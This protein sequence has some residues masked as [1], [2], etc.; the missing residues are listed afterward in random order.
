M[1]RRPVVGIQRGR[2]T[3]LHRAMLVVGLAAT[4]PGGVE[5]QYFGQNKVQYRHMDFSVIATEHFDI[6]YYDGHRQAAIDAARMAERAYARLSHI[7]N[8]EYRQR[9]PIILYGSHTEFQQNNVTDIAEGTGGVTDPFRHRVML[10]FTGSANDFEHVLQHEIVHQFQFDV[11]ARGRIGAG[12]Q[13]LISVNPPLWLMEGMAEYL[14]LGAIDANTAM[15][16]RDAALEGR[17]PTIEQLTYD[18]RVFPYRF[19][20]GLLAHIGSRW[21]DEA[22]GEILHAVAASGVEQGLQ[23]ALGMSLEE[24]SEEWRTAV[25]RAYLPEIADRQRPREFGRPVLTRRRSSGT[26]HVSPALSPDGSEIAYFSEGKSFFVDLYVADAETGKVRRRLVKSAFSTDFESVRFLNSSGTWSR[27][28]KYFAIAAKR[29]GRDDLVIFDM[30]RYRVHRRIEV[31]LAGLTNPSWS[32]DGT[33]LVFTGYDGGLSDLYI[34]NVDG[35]GISRLTHDRFADLH[36]VWSPNGMTI[37]FATDRGDDSDLESLKFGS[38]KV[39]LYSIRSG[40]IDVLPSMQGANSNPQWGPDGRTIAYLSDRT[41]VRNVFLHDLNEAVDYQLTDVFTGIAGITPLSPALSWAIEADRLAFSHYERGRYNVYAVDNPRSLRRQPYRNAD[42]APIVVASASQTTDAVARAASPPM[43]PANPDRPKRSLVAEAASYYRFSG[44]FRASEVVPA[45]GRTEH[46]VSVMRLLDSANLALPDTN[47]F[48]FRTYAAK[49]S[50]DYVVRPTVGYARDNFGSGVFGG[51][52]ISLSDILG[53]HRMVLAGQVNGRIDEAQVLGAYANLS[54]RTNW[55]AGIQQD[56]IFFY[57]GSGFGS[58]AQGNPAF[59]TRLERFVVRQAFI[60]AFRP[61]NRFRRIE[62]GMKAV[63]VDRALQTFEEAYD[64]V[65]GLIY[66]ARLD[67]QGL[68]SNSYIQPTIAMVFDNSLSLYVGPF[69]GRRSRFEYSPAYGQWRFHQFLGDYRRYDRLLGPF[70]LA[71]RLLFFGRFGR[72]SEQFPLFL[73][74]PELVRGYTAGSFR[75]NECRASSP[76]TL[77]SCGAL[78]QLSGS[79]VA[80]ANAELRFPLLRQAALGFL[81]IGFPPIE[82]AFFFDAGLA[83]RAGVDLVWDRST[84]QDPRAVRQPLKSW[85]FSVR[86]NILGFVILRADYAKPLDRKGQGSYWTLSLG[87]TF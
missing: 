29:G 87:P 59:T 61:F 62:F 16:L 17:L 52:A 31:P 46:P 37:A 20:H 66:D 30:K 8:H 83:W 78:D 54:R 67:V 32:P 36:P 7:L 21:G 11:F 75:R 50:P 1:V 15:W 84:G 73:G 10:P 34:I 45:D 64:P 65:S 5:A 12:I 57:S 74:R 24:L 35:T 28:G 19:G 82:G 79:R 68:G 13:R 60:E 9:Q 41:G 76:A 63:N 49:L 53:N 86:A 4:L 44:G 48:I 33:R 26:L 6:H 80:V 70:T 47:E 56:P 72:D 22:I 81:P 40:R 38:L 39:A 77:S 43:Q 14:S 23:R 85:G 2:L 51:T 71:T 18:P 3:V 55:A 69:A 42:P 27:D 25:Q 58:D